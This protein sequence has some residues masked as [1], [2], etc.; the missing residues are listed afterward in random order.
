MSFDAVFSLGSSC[1]PAHQLRRYFQ[2]RP[3]SCFDW[4]VTPFSS[5]SRVF[6]DDGASFCL[7]VAECFD[8]A[9][10]LCAHY[11]VMYHHEFRLPGHSRVTVNDEAKSNARAKLI[12]KYNKMLS[13]ARENRTLFLRY[14]SGTDAPGDIGDVTDHELIS[15]VDIL[16]EKLG[17]SEF[18]LCYIRQDGFQFERSSFHNAEIEHCSFFSDTHVDEQ[19][20]NDDR[21]NALFASKGLDRDAPPFI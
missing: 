14:G 7:D 4:L 10:V 15:I 12:Y 20:G 16:K 9:S 21:W 18:E 2:K 13:I 19:L 5:I 6:A 8:G 17:H 11:G 1:T 3:S